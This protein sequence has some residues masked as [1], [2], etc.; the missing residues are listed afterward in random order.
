MLKKKNIFVAI[1]ITV[2]FLTVSSLT[3][4]RLA[5]YSFIICYIGIIIAKSLNKRLKVPV[6]D[7]FVLTF[8]VGIILAFVYSYSPRLQ[9]H[10]FVLLHSRWEVS[11]VKQIDLKAIKDIRL[12][13]SFKLGTSLDAAIVFSNSHGNFIKNQKFSYFEDNIEKIITQNFNTEKYAN[14]EITKLQDNLDLYIF[15][16]PNK[17]VYKVFRKDRIFY[18]SHSSANLAF[19]IF[20]FIIFIIAVLETLFKF[21]KSISV[22]LNQYPKPH[23]IA[24]IL[25]LIYLIIYSLFAFVI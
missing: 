8:F 1:V 25:T 4:F 24:S 11:K 3:T 18:N 19:S 21:R 10:E 16:K 17:D 7:F 20:F 15:R 13:S 23:F 9:Y 2:F 14:L 22:I 6:V 5:I 12:D